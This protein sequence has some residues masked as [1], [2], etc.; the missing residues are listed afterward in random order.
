MCKPAFINF[1]HNV[2][3]QEL[4]YCPLAVKL[5]RCVR[6]CNTLN[7]LSYKVCVS[8]KTESLHIH[9]F[10]FTWINESKI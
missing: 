4:H 7:D 3:S 2:Y 1:S 8:N 6:S 10:N 9:A 5:D